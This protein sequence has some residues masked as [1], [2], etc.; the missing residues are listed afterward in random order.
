MYESAT[1]VGGG[2]IG[3]VRSIMIKLKERSKP[4]EY[5]LKKFFKKNTNQRFNESAEH[6]KSIE[7]AKHIAVW[8]SM[9]V[10]CRKYICEPVPTEHPSISVQVAP[11]TRYKTLRQYRNEA[12]YN[13]SPRSIENEQIIRELANALACLH[14]HGWAHNDFKFDNIVVFK[15]DGRYRVKLIDLANVEPISIKNAK[16]VKSIVNG[17]TGARMQI[18]VG[19]NVHYFDPPWTEIHAMMNFPANLP[20]HPKYKITQQMLRGGEFQKYYKNALALLGDV[21]L[22]TNLQ[23][24]ERRSQFRTLLLSPVTAPSRPANKPANSPRILSR[25][26]RRK[27]EEKARMSA[28]NRDHAGL[29][30]AQAAKFGLQSSLYRNNNASYI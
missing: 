19:E 23:R 28:I 3:T 1:H 20:N 10:G 15:D 27:A 4:K 24:N 14:R 26:S 7:E 21:P 18:K 16:S 25:F 17:I 8:E 2:N 29:S 6:R 22:P 5:I 30:S 12:V 13:A 9:S 11:P